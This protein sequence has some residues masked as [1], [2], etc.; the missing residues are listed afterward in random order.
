[1]SNNIFQEQNKYSWWCLFFFSNLVLFNMHLINPFS[2]IESM[3]R[4][5][6]LCHRGSIHRPLG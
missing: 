5:T 6:L 3:Y 2:I 4:D 1:M